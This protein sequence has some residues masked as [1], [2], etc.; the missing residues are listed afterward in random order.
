MNIEVRFFDRVERTWGDKVRNAL[1][2]FFTAGFW[3]DWKNAELENAL[4]TGNYDG[5]NHAIIYGA[6]RLHVF[7]CIDSPEKI[8]FA[9]AQ[10]KKTKKIG[11][12]YYRNDHY[13]DENRRIIH[14][15]STC[16]LTKRDE[17]RF[18]AEDLYEAQRVLATYIK[19]EPSPGYSK[20]QETISQ[21]VTKIFTDYLENDK[22]LSS[23]TIAL[24][25]LENYKIITFEEIGRFYYKLE[26]DLLGCCCSPYGMA[27]I[28]YRKF[29]REGGLRTE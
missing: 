11:E 3:K 28:V 7:K 1:A 26:H 12:E 10:I 14:D 16:R 25:L 23:A 15:S 8:S 13:Y 24:N 22:D 21:F 27:N 5:A 9:L 2:N 4:K 20:A 18:V 19:A 6:D 29:V 17:F